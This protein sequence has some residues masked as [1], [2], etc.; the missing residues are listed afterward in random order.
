MEMD[1]TLFEKDGPAKIAVVS[2]GMA[3]DLLLMENPRDWRTMC[4]SLNSQKGMGV[5]S[6]YA[7]GG[8]SILSKSH[9][10]DYGLK[11]KASKR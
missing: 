8:A 6:E 10:A 2:N 1:T 11:K 5:F 7:S 9:R 4:F 3:Y